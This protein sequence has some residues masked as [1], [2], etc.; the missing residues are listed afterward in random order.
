MMPPRALGYKKLPP[1]PPTHESAARHCRRH[2]GELMSPL[3]PAAGQT[4]L[5]V[6]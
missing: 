4:L 5:V 2:L 1:S 3:V 6:T